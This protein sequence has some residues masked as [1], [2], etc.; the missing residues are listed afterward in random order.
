MGRPSEYRYTESHEWVRVDGDVAVVGIT[1]YAV[2]ALRDLVA[3]DF[4]AEDGDISKG[5]TLA[6]IESVKAASDIYAP[7]SGEILEVNAGLG[8][9]IDVLQGDAFDAGW[10]VKIKMSDPAQVKSLLTLE[11][12]EAKLDKK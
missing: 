3:L 8:D 7:V 9:D 11:Q 2:K 5:E 4:E 6:V 12:Y 10:M 1:D